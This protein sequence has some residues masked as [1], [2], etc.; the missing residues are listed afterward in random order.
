[1][2]I[3]VLN[4]QIYLILYVLQKYCYKH[5]FLC[6]FISLILQRYLKYR[7]SDRLDGK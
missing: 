7:D 6:F 4:K 3:C 5:N 2:F 1:M